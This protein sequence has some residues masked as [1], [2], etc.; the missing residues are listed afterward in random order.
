[1]RKKLEWLSEEDLLKRVLSLE[2]NRLLDYYRDMPD[3]DLNESTKGGRNRGDDAA[4]SHR[5]PRDKKDKDRRTAE[6]GMERL[7]VNIGKAQGFFPGNLMDMINKSVAGAKPEIGRIDLMP[8]YTLFDVRKGDARRIL[9]ALRHADFFGVPVRAEIASDRDY[10]AD[11][12]RGFKKGKGEKS[13]KTKGAKGEKS[14]KGAKGAKGG[15][16]AKPEYNGNYDIF[17]NKKHKK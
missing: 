6:P 3:I 17:I 10:E 8:G 7:M 4:D 16:K 5:R 12:R 13:A 9:D 15:K 14:A 2:F 11:S 1:M